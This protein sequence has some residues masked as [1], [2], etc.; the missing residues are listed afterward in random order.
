MTGVGGNTV[1]ANRER[2]A[3]DDASWIHMDSAK[4]PMVVSTLVRFGRSPD[5]PTV[6]TAFHDRVISCFPRFSQRVVAAPSTVGGVSALAWERDSHFHLDNHIQR[7]RA[8]GADPE[9]AIQELV[10]RQTGVALISDRPRWRLHLIDDD[11]GGAAVLLRSHHS[12][13]DGLSLVQVLLALADPPADGSSHP[14]QMPLAVTGEGAPGSVTTRKVSAFD[15]AL[16]NLVKP[17]ALLAATT[18][19]RANAAVYRKL[20]LLAD[21]R[22]PWRGELSGNK[23]FVWTNP[24]PLDAVK[25]VASATGATVNDLALAVVT[26]ALHQYFRPSSSIPYRVGATIPFNLRPLDEPLAPELGNQIGLVF[27][28]LP[29]GIGDSRTR[30]DH[31]RRRMARIKASPEGEIVRAG[32]AMIGAIPQRAMAKAWMD[33]FTR[34]STAVITNIAGPSA[35][36]SLTGVPIESFMLWVPT[37]GQVGVGLSIVTYAGSLRLGVQVDTAVVTDVDRFVKLLEDEL[38]QID[39]YVLGR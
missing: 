10:G 30:L 35:R 16:L 26:G 12:L 25:L 18:G 32:M 23:R 17:S 1:K 36:L 27:V 21:Q 20:G 38:G 31:I 39:R 13:A 8:E 37:S 33:L 28:N 19:A 3:A 22:N 29:V 4:N 7:D 34:K 15:E 14:Q 11:H 2:V 24:A 6:V 5:W 9:R